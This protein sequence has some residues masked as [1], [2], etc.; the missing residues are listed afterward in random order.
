MAQ[1]YATALAEIKPPAVVVPSAEGSPVKKIDA[2]NL[3]QLGQNL[4]HLFMQYV[5]DRRIAELR[6]LRNQRQ[7]LGIYDPEIE[8]EL[9]V[10]RSKAYPRITRVKCISVLSRLMNLMFPGNERNWELSADPD[11]DISLDEVKQAL[12]EAKQRDE[13]AGTQPKLDVEYAQNAIKEFMAGRVGQLE[14]LIDDQLQE[15]GGHQSKDYISLNRDVI[16]SGILYGLGVLKGPM[17]R[18]GRAV[19]W[20]EVDGVPYPRSKKVYKPHFE[21]LPVWD[22]YPD[23]SAKTFA[24]MDGHFTRTVMSRAQVRKLM[25]RADYFPDQI[26]TFLQRNPQGN[27]RAQPFETELRAMGV[28]VNV[29]EMKS[30]TMKYEMITWHGAVSG[31]YL[32]LAGCDVP[33]DK[34]ADDLD[35]EIGMLDGN[36]IRATINPWRMLDADVKTTHVFLFDE[37]DTSPIGFGLPNAIRDSQMA[38]SAATRMLLDNASVGCG[39]QLELNT[40]LLRQDQDLTSTSAYKV[41]YREGSDATAQFPAVRNVGIDSHLPELTKIIELFMKFADAET[42][43][44]PMTGGDM[45]NSPSEPMRTAAGASMLRGDAALP[46]KDIV[47]AFDAFTQSVI[48]SVVQFNKKLNV[49]QTPEGDYDVIARGATSLIAKEMRCIQ[50]DQLT[51][52]LKPEEMIHIDARKLIEVRIKS[53]DMGDVLVSKEEAVRR[54]AQQQQDQRQQVQEATVRK[55]LSDAFKNISQ[56]QKNTATADA[57]TVKA[58]LDLLEKGLNNVNLNPQGQVGADPA[59]PTAQA[60]NGGGMGSPAPGDM[61]GGQQ[62]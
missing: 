6:W 28:K 25:D 51:A 31:E 3:R 45:A 12:Q 49:A 36:V 44:G 30:E 50:A 8:K 39:P 47:R 42:F 62:G 32:R 2:A 17:V 24:S 43:V 40:D 48:E 18:E 41:W 58:V 4:N 52:T 23:L 34:L 26:R 29:N 10:N 19:V 54:Q 60:N 11:A 9:S 35:A 1:T 53:R 7:Y 46:F 61:P 56:G 5:S 21:F 33:D 22:F 14:R 20:D 59:A 37:D 57:A 16:R 13:D 27:Y 15:L 38:I 55:L